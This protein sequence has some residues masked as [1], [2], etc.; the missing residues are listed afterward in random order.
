[1]CEESLIRSDMQEANLLKTPLPSAYLIPVFVTEQEEAYLLSKIEE[2]GGTEI[3]DDIAD[4]GS[5]S[6]NT[7]AR[8]LSLISCTDEPSG[9]PSARKFRSKASRPHQATSMMQPR[10]YH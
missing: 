2:L 9:S 4:S 3:I 5:E 1:M 8:Q 10:Q 7:L 6:H